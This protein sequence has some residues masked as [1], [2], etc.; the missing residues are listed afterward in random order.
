MGAFD[1]LTKT[2]KHESWD[3]GEEV[4]ITELLYGDSVA[5]Q[6][7]SLA[8]LS[9]ADMSDKEKQQSVKMGELDLSLPVVGLLQ[10]CIV[11]W[12]FKKNGKV[13]P[14]TPENI[15]ALRGHYGDYI[16]EKIE[17]LNPTRDEQFPRGLGVGGEKGQ[18]T[19]GDAVS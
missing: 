11:S 8:N 13:L 10:K 6:S 14:V 19:T 2:I 1:K 12:T 18:D 3:E 7:A 16:A 15:K 5:L 4:V 17:E 9:M